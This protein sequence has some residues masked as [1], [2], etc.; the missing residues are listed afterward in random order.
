MSAIAF[1][2]PRKPGSPAGVPARAGAAHPYRWRLNRAG[3]VNVWFYFDQRFTLS[4]G[5]LVLRGSNG[6]GK[7]R[8]LEMLL[9]FVLD[10]DRRRMD[11]TGSGKVRL[12]DLMRAGGDGQT[13]RLGYVWLELIREVEDAGGEQRTEFLTTGALI[14]FSQST[15]EAKAWYFL[16][17]LRVDEDLALLD[18]S[19]VP[20]SREGLAAAI[21][22]DRLTSSPDVHRDRVRTAVFGLH[23]DQGR[24]RYT[25]LLQLL[26]TLRSPDVGNRIDEGRLPQILSDALP[27]LSDKAIATAGEELDGLEETRAALERLE[28]AYGHVADFLRVYTRYATGVCLTA[29]NRAQAAAVLARDT[30][31]TAAQLEKTHLQLV[32]DHGKA[33]AESSELDG[34]RDELEATVAGIRQ[35]SEYKAARE[36]SERLS[37][38]QA[39]SA[40]A[41]NAMATAKGAREEEQRTA[42]ACNEAVQDTKSA[43]DEVARIAQRAGELLV[44]AGLHIPL[45]SVPAVE[46]RPADP[47]VDPVRTAADTDP[48]PVSRP[49]ALCLVPAP[50]HLATAADELLAATPALLSAAAARSQQAAARA[51]E[52][53]ELTSSLEGVRRAQDRA[54]DAAEDAATAEGKAE[55]AETNRDE[56]AAELAVAWRAWTAS[57]RT[58]HLLGHVDWSSTAAAALLGDV[59]ALTGDV[60]AGPE[61]DRELARLD[62]LA[63]QVAAPARALHAQ[64]MASLAT[65]A[66]HEKAQRAQ[67]LT[68]AGELRRERDVPPAV[69]HWLDSTPADAP[70]LWRLLDFRPEV[71]PGVRAGVEG[72]LLASGLLYGVLTRDG[73]VVAGNGQLLLGA[74][75]PPALRSLRTLLVPAGGDS[76]DLARVSAVLDQVAL[77][78]GHPTWVSSDGSWGNGPLTGR[79]LPASARYIGATARAAARAARL[80]EIDVLLEQLQQAAQ[81]RSEQQEVLEAGLRDLE[82]HLVEAPR[83]VRLAALRLQ[84]ASARADAVTGRRQAG[85]LGEEAMRLERAWTARQR[86]HREVC[87]ALGMPDDVEGLRTMQACAEQAQTMC[88]DMDRAGEAVRKHLARGQLLLARLRTVRD[89]RREAEEHAETAG[90]NWSGEDSALAALRE[91]LGS[92]PQ[93]V[94]DRLDATERELKR[95]KEALKRTNSRVLDLTAQTATA[96]EKAQGAREKAHEARTALIQQARSLHRRLSHPALAVALEPG[97]VGPAALLAPN[98]SADDVLAAVREVRAAV[99]QPGSTADATALVRAQSVLERHTTGTYDVT[100]TVEDELHVVEL[101]DASG[102]RHIADAAAEL[103]ERRDRGRSALTQRERTAF[104]NFV[105]GGMAEEL[106]NRIIEAEELIKAMNTSLGPITTSHGI[107]VKIRWR[108]ADSANEHI[109]RIKELMKRD[110]DVLREAESEELISRLK[111]LVDAAYS[112]DPQAGYATHLHTALDYRGWHVVDAFITGPEPGQERKISR[113]AKLS[114]G[115]TRFVSY[116]TLFAAAD[117][118]LSSLPDTGRALRLILLDDAFAKVDHRTIGELMALLVRLDLDFVMTGHALWGFFT[119]VPAL[120]TYEVRRADGT[121][122]VTT[123]VHWDGHTRHLRAA[124]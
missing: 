1:P 99:R 86:S 22:A 93:E 60:P 80:A 109:T 12:E 73:D 16:T 81:A 54:E 59:E 107:G 119:E 4:G 78:P 49:A 103:R 88:R 120:D 96:R 92:S 101:T 69:P 118:Y 63:H 11:A 98:G 112:A 94:H 6:S 113:R 30:G 52:A 84:A 62:S 71:A 95:T 123:H 21:G 105:L 32:G 64:Q 82:G 14:R 13:N 3:I 56:A 15:A 122:A 85:A 25:G 106:R 104:H 44:Q 70:A 108:L 19:R 41:R 35:S 102:R 2:G 48:E 89:R 110:V 47:V 83:S 61:A 66:Q 76:K 27:P 18:T 77:S 10:A 5:R 124:S 37:T 121:A 97:T 45:P 46:V 51:D 67:L 116:V 38:L 75:G 33:V 31:A 23:G 40:A 8:A 68:E 90:Q 58:Q 9:P 20:L 36:L 17:P 100:V 34:Y 111:A 72:A 57:S 43:A 50:D 55:L 117:A 74:G 26:H 24:E 91:S 39:L 28:T 114:Q 29:G 115:E 42:D 7:S 53:R 87:A 65:Q 79:H